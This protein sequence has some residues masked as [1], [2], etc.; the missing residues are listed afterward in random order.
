MVPPHSMLMSR[1]VFLYCPGA[2]T[3]LQV[4]LPG[5]TSAPG[6]PTGKTGTP[7]PW[8]AGVSSA[9][10]VN[11]VDANWNIVP[12]A[13]LSVRL[14]NDTGHLFVLGDAAACQTVRPHLISFSTPRQRVQ[15]VQR[16]S[17]LSSQL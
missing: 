16:A 8:T 1:R 14:S 11:V 9:V 7:S 12:T 3:K 17:G 5:E 15:H 10:I 2:A 13:S 4:L 6:T